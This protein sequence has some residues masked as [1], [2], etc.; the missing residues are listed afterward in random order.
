MSARHVG[1]WED[2]KEMP[3][4]GPFVV[5]GGPVG[6]SVPRIEH[7]RGPEGVGSPV[8]LDMSVYKFMERHKIPRGYAGASK[9]NELYR[10]G[11]FRWEGLALLPV[12]DGE[13]PE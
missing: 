5:C 12:E 9:L 4:E 11:C 6:A 8:M 10:Q 7:A 13:V 3:E 1:Y 2:L